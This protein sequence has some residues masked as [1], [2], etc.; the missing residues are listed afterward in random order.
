MKKSGISSLIKTLI[1]IG[2]IVGSLVGSYFITCLLWN[3]NSPITVVQGRSMEPTLYEGDL[4][5][6]KKPRDLVNIKNGSHTE[7][8]GDILI[9]F[10]PYK[11]FLIVHRVVN[12]KYE[13]GSWYFSTQG[14]NN[15]YTD[16]GILYSGDWLHESY[17]KGVAIG[18]IPWIGNIGI[19]LRDSG[20]GIFLIIIILAYILISTLF[21]SKSEE[22][23]E[24]IKDDEKIDDFQVLN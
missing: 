2:I 10:S 19:F 23:S 20:L 16:N 6:V 15:D 1:I 22:K 18:C 14:D 8:T 7:R 24:K 5:F 11:K 17:V 12:K 4:L 13:N 3:T 9:F 21:E